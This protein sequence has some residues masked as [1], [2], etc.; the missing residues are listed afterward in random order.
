MA[1]CYRLSTGPLVGV[2]L[3]YMLIIVKRIPPMITTQPFGASIFTGQTATMTVA[4]TGQAL[5]YQWYH[6]SSGDTS[7]AVAGATATS[8]T[9]PALTATTNYWVQVSN[10]G[11]A[12]NSVTAM[13]SVMAMPVINGGSTGGGSGGPYVNSSIPFSVPNVPPGTTVTWDFG[14]GG[15]ATGSDVSH[16]FTT[17]GTFTITVT[18][19]DPSGQK[20]TVTAS[21]TVN[22]TPMRLK[23]LNIT[24]NS[25]KDRATLFGVIHVS[26]NTV[27]NGQTVIVSVGG[28]MQ[29]FTLNQNGMGKHG[30]NAFGIR[31]RRARGRQLLD[32]ESPM[33]LTIMGELGTALKANAPLDAQG[34]PTQVTLLVQFNGGYFGAT[35]PAKF[36]IIHNGSATANAKF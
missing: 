19:T 2:K 7:N 26:A 9:T 22:F 30:A 36:K 17:P 20:N 18:L 1:T 11:G 31:G 10:S 13:I 21:M 23:S 29:T 15:M 8:F 4:A 24:L 32:H 34:F 33:R 28:N 16:I 12:A 35:L 27:L 5:S 3:A 14:D 6:G 25:G